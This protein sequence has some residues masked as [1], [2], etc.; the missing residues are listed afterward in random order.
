MK[1]ILTASNY[2]VIPLDQRTN[3]RFYSSI[4]PGSYVP[5]HWHDAIEI[6]YLIEGA[7]K[8]TV[9]GTT[10]ILKDGQCTL[11]QSGQVHSTLCTHP[12][13]SIVFQIPQTFMEKY[14][15]E[16][17]RLNF[18]LS[19]T[20]QHNKHVPESIFISD[21]NATPDSLPI[22]DSSTVTAT[23]PGAPDCQVPSSNCAP[24][25]HLKENLE[26]MLGI[27]DSQPDGALLL[28]NGILFET[29]Y[30]LYHN[31]S[32]PAQDQTFSR[33]SQNLKKLQ[34]VLDYINQNYNRQISLTEI[35]QVAMFD[36]K[37]FCRFFKKCMGTTFLE[38]QNEI[39]ISRI[40]QDLISTDD[41]ISTILERHGFTNYKLFR[42]LF[43]NY[44]E[45]T[46]TQIRAAYKK[47]ESTCTF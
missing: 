41:K 19:E 17:G 30:L 29:L 14:L 36:S 24:L 1:K 33:Q 26:K 9:E 27:M 31:F 10:N 7:L 44:F 38:Y 5:P 4:D 21:S 16:A 2:E 40:Y 34:P 25:P 12:N 22:S 37:Y 13:R 8:V 35:S 43:Y 32:A 23:A 11:I 42:R 18:C 46:P 47:E 6:I 45:A 28:F 3:V 15:P 39:R 20:D